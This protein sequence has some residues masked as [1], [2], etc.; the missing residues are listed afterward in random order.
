MNRRDVPITDVACFHSQQCAEK[1]LKAFL[2]EQRIRFTRTHAL[3]LLLDQCKSVN[4]EFES[5]RKYLERLDNYAVATRY[6]GAKITN[7]MAQSA[8]SAATRVRTFVRDKLN[9][10]K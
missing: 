9:L 1:Y 8:I 2:Q 7:E 5:I 3:F 4:T 10:P 6:P